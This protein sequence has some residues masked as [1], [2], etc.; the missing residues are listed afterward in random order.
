MLAE[1]EECTGDNT[2]SDACPDIWRII[3]FLFFLHL[4]RIFDALILTFSHIEIS[5]P[6]LWLIETHRCCSLPFAVTPW[7]EDVA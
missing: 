5:Q 4:I 2:V 3:F 7:G 6:S 1:T